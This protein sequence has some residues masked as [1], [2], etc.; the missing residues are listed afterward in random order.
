MFSLL[1]SYRFAIGYVVLSNAIL[2]ESVMSPRLSRYHKHIKT[3]G[4]VTYF[5]ANLLFLQQ[6]LK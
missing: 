1:S 2:P 6:L 3:K 4:K 5:A